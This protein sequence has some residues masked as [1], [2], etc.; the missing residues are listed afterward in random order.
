MLYSKYEKRIDQYLALLKKYSFRNIQDLSMEYAGTETSVGDTVYDGAYTKI[1]FPFSYGIQWKDHWFAATIS[2]PEVAGRLFLRMDTQT[3]TLIFINRTPYG[4][5]NPFHKELQITEYKGSEIEIHLQAWGGHRF[6]GYHPSEGGR[7]QACVAIKKPDYPLV[8]KQPQLLQEVESVYALYYDVLTLRQLSKTLDSASFHY[9]HLISSLYKALRTLSLVEDPE[10]SARAIRD[11]LAPLLNA[12]NGTFSP[13]VLSVGSAHLDHAWLWPIAETTRKAA[14]TALNMIH[15]LKEYPEFRFLFS[16]PAQMEAIKESYPS[17]FKQIQDMYRN[18]GWEPNGVCYVEPDCMLP[19]GE[20]LIRQNLL[21]R[22][23]T[24]ALFDGYEGDVFY[25]PD[26]FGYTAAL[27]QILVGCRV[28]YFVTSKLSWNDTNRFPYDVFLWESLDGTRIPAHMIQGAYE[29][30]ND[31]VEVSK[32]YASVAHKEIQS[33]LFRPVGEGDG[34]GG[35]QRSDL[36]LMRRQSDLQGMPRNR[37]ATLSEAMKTIFTDTD[38]LPVYKGE[39]YLELHRGTYTSQARL[40]QWNRKL[41][42]LLSSYE[43]LCSVLY[44]QGIAVDSYCN[45]VKKAWKQVLINQFHD[46]LPGSSVQ[47]VNEQAIQGYE[48]A[49]KLL[50]DTFSSLLQID[51]GYVLNTNGFDCPLPDGTQL[52]SHQSM[53]QKE[54]SP[55]VDAPPFTTIHTDWAMVTLDTSGR[56]VSLCLEKEARELLPPGSYFNTLL[57]GEDY[58]VFW[59]AWDIEKDSLEQLKPIPSAQTVTYAEDKY[60]YLVTSKFAIGV[61]STLNQTMRIHKKLK[62]ITFHTTIDWQER[63]TIL[64]V[65]FPTTVRSD[66]AL[67]DVPF[68]TISRPTHT[69]TSHEQA[70]FE[71]PA[72]RWVALAD[73]NVTVALCSDSKYGYHATNGELSLS[74]LR[75]PSAPDPE[76]DRG[77]H[78]V[79][80]ELVVSEDGLEEIQEHAALLNNPP[81][82]VK[83]A[84]DPLIQVDANAVI[85][86]TVKVSEDGTN[87]VFRLREWLGTSCIVHPR[88]SALLDPS[89]VQPTNMLEEPLEGEASYSFKPYEVKTFT[90][91][92]LTLGRIEGYKRI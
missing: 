58:P 21:G 62:K 46:I 9:Q 31:P 50:Q 30:T 59:D 76:A 80:Y 81:I 27:P 28:Q 44:A 71:V 69:N 52:G 84:I 53:R 37:W 14:R 24:R 48:L 20:S 86:E 8:F 15:L 85:V 67:Y 32:M 38:A 43:Y 63:H 6:P 29:G 11:Q 39:L 35:T 5:T 12:K 55:V 68:G 79:T 10:K 74:L 82:A 60:S 23:V 49:Y 70:K 42:G 61:T 19:S 4:A 36:E 26:S 87:L 7:V 77:V 2:V 17:V 90:I 75:S 65:S 51:G 72:H 18:G 88:F 1:S 73:R 41:E 40:K 16:Q 64:R 83:D 78:D 13:Q 56:V 47:V 91:K 92:R 34:G 89:T 25:L 33:T 45:S 3:D 22:E 54:N 66:Y 57:I